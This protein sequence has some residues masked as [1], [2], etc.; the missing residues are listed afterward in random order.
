MTDASWKRSVLRK[1][2]IADTAPLFNAVNKLDA[3]IFNPA[4]RKENENRR[5]ALVV[6]SFNAAS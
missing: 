6:S 4:S 3:N 2:M 5:N 1:D